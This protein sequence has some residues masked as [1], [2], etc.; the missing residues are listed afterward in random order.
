MMSPHQSD[1]DRFSFEWFSGLAAYR[2]AN[3]AQLEAF[4]TGLRLAPPSRAWTWRAGS[5]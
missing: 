4:L 5:A 3:R 2:D 1:G